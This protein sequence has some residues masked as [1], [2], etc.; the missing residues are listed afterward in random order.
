MNRLKQ[1]PWSSAT[2][3]GAV[4]LAGAAVAV[5]QQRPLT[6]AG[7]EHA[8]ALSMTFRDVAKN[9]LPAVVSIETRTKAVQIGAN[10]DQLR[11]PLEDEFL[12][13]FFGGELPP[14]MS[15]RFQQRQIPQ[16]RG[17]GSGFIIDGEG[18]ILTNSHVVSGADRVTVKL[19]DGRELQA[20]E[21][22]ADPRADVAIIRV[23][24]GDRLPSVP[25]G[26]SSSMEIGDLVL[27]LGNPFDIGVSVT[28]GII[29]AKGRNTGGLNEIENYLQTDAAINPGNSGGPLVNLRG[30]VIGINT[31][32]S[33]RSGG[34]DGVGFAIPIDNARWIAD[35]LVATGSVNRAY[36][37]VVLQTMDAALRDQFGV[38]IGEGT[39]VSEVRSG[40]PA[41]RAG[42]EE[43]DVILEFAGQRIRNSSHLVAVVER[44][45]VDESYS[46]TVIR[47]GR[48]QQLT[49]TLK[50]MPK[51]YTP[52]LKRA[53]EQPTKPAKQQRQY[54]E[55]GLQVIGLDSDEARQL[56]VPDDVTGV[57]VTSVEPGSAAA[58]AGLRRGDV[59]EKVGSTQ[60]SSTDE[61][62]AAVGEVSVD[63]GIAVLIRRG[64]GSQFVVLK[65]VD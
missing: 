23:D 6:P 30:E 52:A 65:A 40:T 20:T 12:K 38:S 14:G 1:R 13:R 35:Q 7:L 59:I 27:A 39:L 15:D 47:N 51:D 49:V 17:S 28:S 41:A 45:P 3:A 18:V 4:L 31:A 26:D 11:S 63:K 54:D 64:P 37:G 19:H 56:S 2:V 16:R 5:S 57:L 50:P 8:E 46:T 34:Y 58:E 21:W 22:H 32:I 60:V 62:A 61:F 24:A 48:R 33:S 43:G 10:G 44:L 36:L 25:L 9:V 53:L 29:S 42:I 55:L